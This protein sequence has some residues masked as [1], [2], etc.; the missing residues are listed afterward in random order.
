LSEQA[1]N[2]ANRT[3]A[4]QRQGVDEINTRTWLFK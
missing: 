1:L 2:S 4:I 3:A